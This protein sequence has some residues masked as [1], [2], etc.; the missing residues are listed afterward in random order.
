MA[1]KLP[2][3]KD[4]KK[5]YPKTPKGYTNFKD[6]ALNIS[7]ISQDAV[8]SLYKN[9]NRTAIRGTV[10]GKAESLLTIKDEGIVLSRSVNEINFTG[11]G[12]TATL[13]SNG[14]VQVNVNPGGGS[15]GCADV[16][17]CISTNPATIT[18]LNTWLLGNTSFT[19]LQG[20][21]TTLNGL[22]TQEQI[23]DWVAP[24]FTSGGQTGISFVYNDALNR[25][26]ATVTATG[27]AI[28]D[29]GIALPAQPIMN[30]VGGGVTVTTSGGKYIVTIP[31][32]GSGFSCTDVANC[33][34][35]DAGVQTALENFIEAG[36]FATTGTWSF[37]NPIT[38]NGIIN[39]GNIS[40]TTLGVTGLTTLNNLDVNGTT[41]ID[42]PITFSSTV[43]FS[44]TSVTT[45]QAGSIENY[46]DEAVLNFA[47]DLNFLTG[48]ETS[49]SQNF[50]S[51]YI[52]NYADNSVINMNG[53]TNYGATSNTTFSDNSQL[54]L[55]WDITYGAT[56]LVTGTLNQSNLVVNN[57]NVD[58]TND[59]NSSIT[60][61][62][63][64]I[65]NNGVTT[66]NTGVSTNNYDA[67]Y[68][69]N[70]VYNA[71]AIVNNTGGTINNTNQTVNNTNVDETFDATS[72][73]TYN[74]TVTYGPT[75]VVNFNQNT[76]NQLQS[77]S[78][79]ARWFAMSPF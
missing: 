23:Q 39:T 43:T 48:N 55:N 66:N 63:N 70:N 36:N 4:K 3:E 35:S 52:G 61:N 17:N 71:A 27:L 59:S 1:K 19:T 41:T 18:A 9:P 68:V 65:T 49:G 25:I 60:N 28:E 45:H 34:T 56:S 11:G 42:G 15:F 8:S 26:E 50:L 79:Y 30:F 64:T 76:L 57:T 6:P 47:G 73:V 10:R 7:K 54:N 78:P 31:W 58:T 29:E 72:T 75:A 24:L 32:G 13:T 20:Q 5:K 44:P 33:I 22:V 67:T 53:D 77:D 69:G 38:T 2:S 62:G 16:A 46:L 37:A 74:G 21:V 12:I 40:T 51:T 14:K